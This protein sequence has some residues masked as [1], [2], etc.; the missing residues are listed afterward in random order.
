MY[1]WSE[2]KTRRSENLVDFVGEPLWGP[3]G[4]IFGGDLWGRPL[5]QIIGGGLWGRPLGQT[6]GADLWGRPVREPVVVLCWTQPSCG[7]FRLKAFQSYFFINLRLHN[8]CH[9]YFFQAKFRKRKTGWLW[10]NIPGD[11]LTITRR[12]SDDRYLRFDH[13]TDGQS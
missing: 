7:R 8:H 4:E 2:T 11:G 10:A 3:L 13:W 1:V 9:C 5:G 12:L 6:F